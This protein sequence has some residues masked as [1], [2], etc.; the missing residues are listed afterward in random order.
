MTHLNED[1]KKV[2]ETKALETRRHFE[3]VA[4]R[5]ETKLGGLGEESSARTSVSPESLQPNPLV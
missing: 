3:V 2:I 5:L 4:Q 1:L